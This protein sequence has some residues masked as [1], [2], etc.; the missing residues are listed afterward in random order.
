MYYEYKFNK[1]NDKFQKIKNLNKIKG[2]LTKML[3]Q[4][5]VSGNINILILLSALI[6]FAGIIATYISI[7][8][9]MEH[10]KRK[11][12]MVTYSRNLIRY[13]QEHPL[14]DDLKNNHEKHLV[15][16]N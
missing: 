16:T 4:T 6:F 13:T 11:K 10:Y 3:L 15:N 1:K 9:F 8:Y 7:I 14:N 12:L 2:G 5:S